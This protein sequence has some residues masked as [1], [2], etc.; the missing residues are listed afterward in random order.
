[1]DINYDYISLFKYDIKNI[2]ELLSKIDAS[3]WDINDLRQRMFAV[4]NKTKSIVYVWSDF[5]DETYDNV[6]VLIPSTD[7]LHQEVWKI[8]HEILNRYKEGKITKLMLAKLNSNSDIPEHMDMG[9][10]TK[11]H[12]IHLPIKTNK[13]CIFSINGNAYNFEE[14]EV[15]EINNQRPHAVQNGEEERIHLICDILGDMK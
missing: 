10:L 5:S 8:A 6:Q 14:G 11:I 4:H 15:I 2:N 12:R 7:G 13:K 9:N 3:L 1:M